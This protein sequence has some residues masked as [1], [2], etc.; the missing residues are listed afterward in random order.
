MSSA[1]DSHHDNQQALLAAMGKLLAPFA[2]L[3]LAK[4]VPIQ[5]VEELVRQAFV[6]AAKEACTDGNANRMTSRISTMT[7][8]TRR[9]VSRLQNLNSPELPAT[10]SV[11]NDVLTLWVSQ[12]GYVDADGH[13]LTIARQG[14]AP[15]FDALASSVTKD[16]H[17][18]SLLMEM[19]RLNLVTLN[20]DT[21]QVTLTQDTFV[22]RQQWG[23]MVGFLGV[24]VGDHMSAAVANVL[25]T[26]Q[27]HFEQALL[28]DELS[29]ESVQA[30]KQMIS[31]QWRHLM[32]TMGPALQSL[33][34]ADQAANRPQDKALRI[35][36]YSWA[37]DMANTTP[38]VPNHPCK[39][40]TP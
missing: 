37:H 29:A 19:V 10:R 26:G 13:A 28:A 34:D 39:D 17:P 5:A 24:N 16:V 18:R 12:P 40:D 2:K 23:Q 9:E 30:A 35:G 11:A 21:D 36:L 8:L 32:T 6:N 7:G 27:Q 14:V 3:C 22:P 1:N 20:E 25:G 15:S 31:D 4:G 38:P 33:M